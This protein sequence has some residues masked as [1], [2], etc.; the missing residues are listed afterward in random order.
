MPKQLVWA[1]GCMLL[2]TRGCFLHQQRLQMRRTVLSFPITFRRR[3]FSFSPTL[4]GAQGAS[5]LNMVQPA[6]WP[7]GR[8]TMRM[9]RVLQIRIMSIIPILADGFNDGAPRVYNS[10]KG[11]K[12]G[13]WSGTKAVVVRVDDSAE[14][15]PV[16]GSDFKVHSNGIK[17]GNANTDI[18]TTSATWMPSG[19]VLNP[20]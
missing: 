18:F 10:V 16:A 5:R 3:R 13:I 11:T 9:F 2:T 4:A 8:I 20:E 14:I 19:T 6:R 1:C 15:L 12:G 17:S 7:Q